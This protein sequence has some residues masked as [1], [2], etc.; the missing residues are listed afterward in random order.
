LAFGV[1]RL[2]LIRDDAQYKPASKALPTFGFVIAFF[3]KSATPNGERK[4]SLS[5]ASLRCTDS[6]P[7]D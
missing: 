4:T 6:L 7:V 5:G 2:T 1:Q 3:K